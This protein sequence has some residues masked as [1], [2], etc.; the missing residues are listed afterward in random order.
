MKVKSEI[1]NYIVI[2][3]IICDKCGNSCKTG[4]EQANGVDNNNRPFFNFDYLE[5]SG[6]FGFYS[7][8][9]DGE[10]WEAHVC[11]NCA[12]LLDKEIVFSKI[13]IF[14]GK[15]E[16]EKFKNTEK[17]KRKLLNFFRSL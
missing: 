15:I 1:N 6:H 12:D 7:N 5:L 11:Q 17:R 3:D 2:S 4:G 16:N 14:G 10:T 8:N 13:G 9:K